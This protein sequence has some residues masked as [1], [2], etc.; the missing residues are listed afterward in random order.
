M[1][2]LFF[3]REE[4]F[5]KIKEAKSHIRILGAVSFDL[6]YNY[7]REDWYNRINKG[8]F[9]V[10]IICESESDL[11]YASLIS[12]N[13]KAS[14]QD[15]SYN[16]GDFMRIKNEPKIKLRDYFLSNQCKHIEPKGENE[17]KNES[18][19]FSLRTC[20]LRIPVPAI[21]IDDDYY[22]TLSFDKVLYTG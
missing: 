11:T 20:Y 15:R 22:Y 3:S 21:N 7:F 17:D 19:C 6:P 16:I 5:V 4:L 12:D 13:K 8:E 1:E 18:Q 9:L 14:R 10:E 2:Q